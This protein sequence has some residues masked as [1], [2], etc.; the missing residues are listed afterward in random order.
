MK[1]L[2]WGGREIVQTTFFPPG[3]SYSLILGDD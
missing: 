2:Y 1:A 3:M